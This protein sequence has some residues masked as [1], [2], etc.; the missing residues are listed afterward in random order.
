M[1]IRLEQDK[2]TTTLHLAGR[3]DFNTLSVFHEACDDL[4]VQAD[5][6]GVE[7]NLHNVDYL[8]SSALSVL[9]ML[10]EKLLAAGKEITLSGAR[11]NV[12]QVFDIANFNRLFRIV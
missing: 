12:R 2:T 1:Q 5:I 6:L 11:G 3:F 8:D 4:P 7:I 9:L 10:R